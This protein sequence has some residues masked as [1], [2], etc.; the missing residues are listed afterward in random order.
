MDPAGTEEVEQWSLGV[1]DRDSLSDFSML[2]TRWRFSVG[3]LL[4]AILTSTAA[5]QV[6]QR[7]C[8]EEPSMGRR[9]GGW[10]VVT[11]VFFSKFLV[12][13]WE[14]AVCWWVLAIQWL[15]GL[16]LLVLW[17][18]IILFTDCWRAFFVHHSQKFLKKL[19]NTVVIIWDFCELLLNIVLT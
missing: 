17:L 6:E 1:H 13:Q 2:E 4:A 5:Q 18:V 16:L 9:K 3:L 7:W 11:E 12:Q 8:C 19:V 15:Q 14:L 10:L